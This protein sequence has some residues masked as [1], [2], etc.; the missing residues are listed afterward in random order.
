MRFARNFRRFSGKV[1]EIQD[2][3]GAGRDRLVQYPPDD[4]D[5]GPTPGEAAQPVGR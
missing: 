1:R 5:P 2:S 3:S 4:A